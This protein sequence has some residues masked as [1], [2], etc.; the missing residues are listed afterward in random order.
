MFWSAGVTSLIVA[1]AA[2]VSMVSA[3]ADSHQPPVV[4]P[5]AAPTTSEAAKPA[6]PR[7]R[8]EPTPAVAAATPAPDFGAWLEVLRRDALT[9]GISQATLDLALTT[10]EAQPT[11]L[12]R[13]R[14]QAEFTLT[15]PQYIGRRL[16]PGTVNL[17][18]K[19]AAE[20]R[21]LL[22]RV[23]RAHHVPASTVV[24]VWALES[25]FGRFSGVRPT[26][27]VLA[28]LA[29]DGRRALLFRRELI[30]AL[31]I[32]DRGDIDL[33]GM[34]GSWAGAMGQ[35]QF[36]PSS[37]LKYAQDFDA[38]G[39]RNI[40]SS[41]PDV[42][43]SIAFYLK[44]NGWKPGESWGRR[45]RV[46]E[47]VAAKLTEAAPLR[48]VGCRAERGLTERFPLSRWNALGVQTAT[49]GRLPRADL[50]A[51]LLRADGEAFLVY[52]NYETLL[53][54]NCA[55]TYALSV[56]LLSDR[57]D[58]KTSSWPTP[59]KKPARAKKKPARAPRR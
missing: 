35:P 8:V 4:P 23:Q 7:P 30:D 10:V 42:F 9:A 17:A 13:D 12:E 58:G 57:L 56:A 14:A 20:H 22:G 19:R 31:R 29:F 38:D 50:Q 49:G 1:A 25:N 32:L 18:K 59:P 34:Q 3:G 45:V 27:S 52:R 48:T 26:V 21:Q 41:L 36:L 47:A 46:P 2:C 24:S 5:A 33:P 15:L 37:Y 43:A 28:T 44:S 54:Y 53:T 16:G 11:V 39:R 55:H 6:D 51:S 40:W